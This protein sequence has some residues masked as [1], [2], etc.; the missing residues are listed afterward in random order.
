MYLS[1]KHRSAFTLI[2]LL[3]VIAIIAILAAILFPVFAQAREKARAIGCLSNSKQLGTAILMYAQ[4]YD[5]QLVPYK[6]FLSAEPV[7]D[8]LKSV[9]VN[10]LQPYIKS[11]ANTNGGTYDSVTA[12]HDANGLMVCPDKAESKLQ[13]AADSAECD[14]DGT[15]GSNGFIPPKNGYYLAYYAVAFGGNCSTPDACSANFGLSRD[16][17]TKE[18]PLFHYAGAYFDTSLPKVNGRYQF[19]GQSLASINEAA[20]TTIAADGPTV[21]RDGATR[22]VTSGFGCEAAKVHTDGG[23]FTFMDG[24]AKYLKGN[25]ERYVI[26]ASD[27][28]WY[29]QYFTFDK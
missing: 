5:E 28:L 22:R 26:Q 13:E 16:G 7:S 9:W 27:G 12:P 19:V 1:R 11:G 15:A 6:L 18:S 21:I 29:E 4:D 24:H 2:E 23:N 17:K 8:Q 3:V 10:T 14:G 20:R 25:A